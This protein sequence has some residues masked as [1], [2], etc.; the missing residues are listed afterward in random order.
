MS[1]LETF[2][3]SPD[4]KR[5]YIITKDKHPKFDNDEIFWAK[6]NA[7]LTGTYMIIPGNGSIGVYN[8]VYYE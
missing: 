8:S 3:W 7:L 2:S 6:I 4:K 5:I 1:I